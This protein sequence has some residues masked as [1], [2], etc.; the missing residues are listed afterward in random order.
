MS[1]PLCGERRIRRYGCPSSM[2]NRGIRAALVRQIP[3][4]CFFPLWQAFF[5]LVEA[6]LAQTKGH[7][8][9]SP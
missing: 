3:D 1:G 9:Q 2:Q 4:I 6:S 7:V 5:A 8:S